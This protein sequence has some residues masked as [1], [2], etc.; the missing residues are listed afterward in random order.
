MLRVEAVEKRMGHD[1]VGHHALVPGVSKTAQTFVAARCL[2]DSLHVP[3]MTILSRLR[4]PVMPVGSQ[5]S[6]S[7]GAAKLV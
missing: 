6:T 2:E 1:V 5:V 7:E 4:K 3:M